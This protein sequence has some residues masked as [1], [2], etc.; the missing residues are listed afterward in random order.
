M[1]T[2]VKRSLVKSLAENRRGL[3]TVEYAVGAVGIAI[4]VALS[5]K[6]LGYQVSG[7]MAN[8]KASSTGQ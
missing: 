8:A 3:T 2:S 4:A 6:A 5:M 1:K 7:T